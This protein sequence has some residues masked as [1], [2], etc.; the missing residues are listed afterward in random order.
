MAPGPGCSPPLVPAGRRWEVLGTATRTHVHVGLGA[1]AAGTVNGAWP[2]FGGTL[3][4]GATWPVE[5]THLAHGL[6]FRASPRLMQKPAPPVANQKWTGRCGRGNVVRPPP[7]RPRLREHPRPPPRQQGCVWTHDSPS[8]SR[9]P[10]P[11]PGWACPGWACRC[12]CP[13][14]VGSW[15]AGGAGPAR[16][17]SCHRPHG[18]TTWG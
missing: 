5:Q 4:P 7:P 2:H 9:R 8:Y 11:W 12:R 13:G 14:C 10:S 6:I 15:P 18:R 3:G 16:S 17:R 1:P